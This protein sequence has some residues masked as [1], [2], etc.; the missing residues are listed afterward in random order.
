MGGEGGRAFVEDVN[1]FPWISA[2]DRTDWSTGLTVG[3]H[4]SMSRPISIDQPILDRS[5]DDPPGLVV[6]SAQAQ[7]QGFVTSKVAS[8]HLPLSHDYLMHVRL[9]L[10]RMGRWSIDRMKRLR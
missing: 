5:A 2:Y 3:V 10:T 7:P 1:D 4:H 9:V 8:D 6:L